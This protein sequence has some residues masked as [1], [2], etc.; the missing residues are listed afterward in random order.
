MTMGIPSFLIPSVPSIG[1]G[2]MQLI[3]MFC[4][5]HS[6]AKCFVIAS[7]DDK[8]IFTIPLLGL[9]ACISVIHANSRRLDHS[10]R[11]QPWQN[12]H[13]S[14]IEEM[15]EEYTFNTHMPHTLVAQF[16][17]LTQHSCSVP[18][19]VQHMI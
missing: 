19:I 12:L 5:P 4:G 13:V 16:S 1:P 17:D 10:Y 15:K 8:M 18:E 2:A 9:L 3:R 7:A 11:W 6:T 14:C